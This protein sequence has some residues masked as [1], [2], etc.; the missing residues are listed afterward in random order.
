M[1][2]LV[3]L[4]A[5]LF[6]LVFSATAARADSAV[7][8]GFNNLGQVGDGTTE[9]YRYAPVAV[10]GM[11][12]GVTDVAGGGQHSLAVQNGGVYGWGNN[13]F[14]QL[15]DGTTTSA[16]GAI[17]TPVA[18]TG[19]ATGVTAIAAGGSHSLAIQNG[20]VYAWGYNVLG[21]L[22]DG[23][24]TNRTTPV[25]VTDMD[26]G[27]SAV[28]AGVNYSMAIQNGG[29][30][31]WGYGGFGQLGD[32]TATSRR[33]TPVA[34]SGLGNGVTAVAAGIDH[35]LAV[36]N[37]GLFAW[38]SNQWGKL[39]DGTT[40]MRRTPAAIAG[41]TSGVTDVAVG[42]SH[43]LAVVN[44]HVYAWGYNNYGQ[45]GDGTTT[46]RH[47]PV[48]IE[49]TNLRN[50][51]AVAAGD[52]S[53]YALSSDGSLWVWG[54]NGTGA[55]GLGTGTSFKYLT[56]QHLLP[57]TGYVFTSIDASAFA[58]RHAV[59]TLRAIPEPSTFIFAAAALGLWLARRRLRTLSM[60][61]MFGAFV[62][63]QQAGAIT[64]ATVPIGNPGNPADTRFQ[65]PGE[66]VFGAVNYSF[67]IGTTEVTNTQYVAFLNSVAASDPYGL[68]NAEMGS[69]TFGGIVRSGL[70]G[71]Y[72]YAVKASAIGYGPGGTGYAYENKPVVYVGSGDAQRFVNWLHNGQPNGPQ[73]ANTTE[74][75]AYT[76]DGAVTDAALAAVT[77]NAAARWWLPNINEW[78]KAAYYD[79]IAGLYHTYPT[80]DD[81]HPDNNSPSNDTGN[82]ANYFG[83][84]CTTGN[85]DFP[86]TDAGAYTLSGSPYG[87]FDQHGNVH[88][89]S[90]TMPN[91]FERFF[92]GGSWGDNN[93]GAVDLY[94][95]GP[96][97]IEIAWTGFRVATIPDLPGD[98]NH[99]NTVDAADYVEW[100]KNP[101]AIYT[102]D[103]YTTWRANFG[104]TAGS[105]SIASANATV[106]EPTTLVMLI[107]TAAAVSTRRRWREWPVSK[108]NNV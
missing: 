48:E 21:Q 83:G 86:L 89:W 35:S 108:L 8:W 73:D 72:S 45:V 18:V 52:S 59:A 50:I 27:V 29:L 32:G 14:G 82:S 84:N 26:S 28:E 66:P 97:S 49:P 34:V 53:S 54:Y 23:T 47:T 36:Q 63:A 11:E 20:G 60:A 6:I 107:V 87:T 106:P 64:I 56:P 4:L 3:T 92:L 70:P 55:L 94:W 88:D 61:A 78:Y 51:V 17:P 31:A 77:R 39:G 80:G 69:E 75:G 16:F 79:P 9:L 33:F 24:F 25:P 68:Y 100:R 99:D 7:A 93:Y 81:D 67:R 105:G 5:T 90:E 62:L 101:G 42:T 46:E 22:G 1:Q 85:C 44:G 10:S 15:G 103:D 40:T 12:S 74:D 58:G 38:G 76:L 91:G 57:P 95:G 96:A 13:R 2:R 41:L 104:Q 65:P 30:F 43:S 98:F 71:S 102:P 37:G 19:L